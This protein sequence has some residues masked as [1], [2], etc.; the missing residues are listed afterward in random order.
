ME[1]KQEF[2]WSTA[3]VLRDTAYASVYIIEDARGRVARKRKSHMQTHAPERR[4]KTEA[5][6]LAAIAKATGQS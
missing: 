4:F 1:G 2:D 6:A 3:R 5:A